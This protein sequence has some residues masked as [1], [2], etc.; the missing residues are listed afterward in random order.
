MEPTAW[1][2]IPIQASVRSR[3][4]LLT[5]LATPGGHYSHATVA[6]GLVFISGQLPITKDGRKLVD[7]PFA[8]QAMQA[9]ANV[10][11]ALVAAGS[12]IG[13]L[14]QVRVYVDSIDNWPAF[15]AI[16]AAWAGAARPARAVVPTGPLHFGL[17]VEVEAVALAS[18]A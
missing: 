4:S 17:K 6:N 2:V 5:T 8:E 16:Y 12:G 13:A 18:R 10:E 15:N 14:V 7:A 9:L 3:R 1:L 11:A